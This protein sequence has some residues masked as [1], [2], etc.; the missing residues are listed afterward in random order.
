MCRECESNAF[1]RTGNGKGQALCNRCSLE[2]A[3]DMVDFESSWLKKRMIKL[4]IIAILTILGLL[5]LTQKNGIAGT[6]V[7]WF[8]A[9]LVSEIGNKQPMSVRDSVADALHEYK[10]PF[11]HMIMSIAIHTIA[12]PLFLIAG[13]IGYIR[14]K[15]QYTKDLQLLET[16]KAATGAA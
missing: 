15:M 7:L 2:E 3:Q 16:I 6:I 10:Y 8:I 5:L 9:G 4:V 14:S 12:G 11:S 1:L 13:I